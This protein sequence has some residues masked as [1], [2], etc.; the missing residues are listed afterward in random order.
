MPPNHNDQLL[1]IMLSVKDDLSD[2]RADV[3]VALVRIARLE[4]IV[5]G[6]ATI[7]L[8]SV[9]KIIFGG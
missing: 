4:K 5:Y 2:Y 6:V 1:D 7:A 8:A 9:A 3:A